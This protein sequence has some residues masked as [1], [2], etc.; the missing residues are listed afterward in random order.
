[1]LELLLIIL[2]LISSLISIFS[3]LQSGPF[4]S[5]Q[6]FVSS[7][8][9]RQQL[10]IKD[11]YFFQGTVFLVVAILFILQLVDLI[12]EVAYMGKITVS[13]SIVLCI[14]SIIRYFQLESQTMK[15]YNK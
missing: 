5:I 12:I 8:R 6:Y 14:Y 2:I 11:R 13:I 10:K 15:K 1:M 7:Q 9:E 4:F 3:F